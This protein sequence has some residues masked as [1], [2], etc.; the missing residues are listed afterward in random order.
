MNIKSQENKKQINATAKA[1]IRKKTNRTE[2]GQPVN[3]AKHKFKA[4]TNIHRIFGHQTGPT[5]SD[6]I[7]TML[8]EPARSD[9]K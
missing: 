4:S 6:M 1:I 7:K 2:H 8:N 5:H 9:C 3:G